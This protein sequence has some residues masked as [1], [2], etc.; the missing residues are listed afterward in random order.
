MAL[1]FM[2]PSMVSGYISDFLGYKL[3]FIWVLVATIP[4]FLITYLAPFNN[5]QPDDPSGSAES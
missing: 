3:F 5:Q 4:S 1:G 2:I